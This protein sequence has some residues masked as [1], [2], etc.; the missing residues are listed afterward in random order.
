MHFM[1]FMLS[2]VVFK[3]QWSLW[4]GADWTHCYVQASKVQV[5][6]SNV[7][8]TGVMYYALAVMYYAL[9]VFIAHEEWCGPLNWLFETSE[10]IAL[11]YELIWSRNIRRIIRLNEH[12][13]FTVLDPK[14]RIFS[15]FL[16]LSKHG[17]VRGTNGLKD[18]RD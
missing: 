13:F 4:N 7:L 18:Q 11:A 6:G 16:K 9:A 5:W 15:K 8:C 12:C 1:Y 3:C 14:Y 17:S 2:L 10:N